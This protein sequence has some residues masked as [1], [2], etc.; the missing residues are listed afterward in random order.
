MVDS[1][2]GKNDGVIDAEV[3]APVIGNGCLGGNVPVE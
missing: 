1:E 3:A 2:G